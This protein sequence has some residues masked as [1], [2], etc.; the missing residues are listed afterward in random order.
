MTS[1]SFQYSHGKL[2]DDESVFMK[3]QF[4]QV[5]FLTKLV[6]ELLFQNMIYLLIWNMV[7]AFKTGRIFAL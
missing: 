6:R 7:F 4:L 2:T 3:H 1:E 5:L